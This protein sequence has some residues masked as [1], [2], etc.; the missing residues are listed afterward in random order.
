MLLAR[1]CSNASSCVR[2]SASDAARKVTPRNR[3]RESNV[4]ESVLVE[5]PD[6]ETRNVTPGGSA[7]PFTRP[8]S[9]SRGGVRK[10]NAVPGDGPPEASEPGEVALM[11]GAAPWPSPP[12][13][14]CHHHGADDAVTTART[15]AKPIESLNSVV[16]AIAQY[17][18]FARRLSSAGRGRALF[19]RC[20]GADGPAAFVRVRLV[21][22]PGGFPGRRPALAS[23]GTRLLRTR[24]QGGP[25]PCPRHSRTVGREST[26]L[27]AASG[28]PSGGFRQVGVGRRCGVVAGACPQGRLAQRGGPAAAA[29]RYD[30]VGRGSPGRLG[31]LGGERP[32][33]AA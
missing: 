25:G 26:N 24:K 5:H 3:S 13:T 32:G 2:P 27:G 33:A 7:E 22:Q 28:N 10:S 21:G 29:E 23:S 1:S 18:A 11:D 12:S 6:P 30:R 31:R 20:V 19:P 15:I 14:R 9:R 16:K 17:G 8:A 4:S